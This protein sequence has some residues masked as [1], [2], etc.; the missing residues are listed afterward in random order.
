MNEKTFTEPTLQP[1]ISSASH[2]FNRREL[3]GMKLRQGYP[4]DRCGATYLLD[5]ANDI[6]SFVL[7]QKQRSIKQ[8]AK[9]QWLLTTAKLVAQGS[10][11]EGALVALLADLPDATSLHTQLLV[12]RQEWSELQR[13]LLAKAGQMPSP[14]SGQP[15]SHELLA[16]VQSLDSAYQTAHSELLAEWP[17][18]VESHVLQ[19]ELPKLHDST[20]QLCQRH[21]AAAKNVKQALQDEASNLQAYFQRRLA[22]WQQEALKL[23][24]NQFSRNHSTWS[25]QDH[26]LL[27]QM[28]Q[29]F[30]SDVSATTKACVNE[31]MAALL[32]EKTVPD[33]AGHNEWLWQKRMLDR[34]RRELLCAWD[35]AHKAFLR[36]SSKMLLQ[37][38]KQQ[39]ASAESAAERL[40][41]ISTQHE[42]HDQLK[43]MRCTKYVTDALHAADLE[44]KEQALAHR[45]EEEA[46][47][48]ELRAEQNKQQLALYHAALAA[49]RA[50]AQAA[51]DAQSEEEALQARV[52]FQ[53]NLERVVFRQAATAHK[54]QQ[55][56]EQALLLQQQQHDRED[57]L[58]QLRAQ[59]RVEVEADPDRARAP[60]VA[61]AAQDAEPAAAFA[62]V[63]GYTTETLLKDKRFKVLEAL[64]Q[65]S[66]HNTGY[67]RHALLAVSP[68][69]KPRRDMLST[70]AA[71]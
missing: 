35:N 33:I 47:E 5:K 30:A 34:R 52:L 66:L 65:Q 53:A 64:R 8:S 32:P 3:V 7:R 46:R 58:D 37:S 48:Q 42:L 19:D 54:D 25:Q 21:P 59:V 51:A 43:V 26:D 20:A 23:G 69:T 29:Q 24:S 40:K 38:K 67:A 2:C 39:A 60:T 11:V 18:A 68:A 45:Q 4:P 28:S 36:D 14:C 49:A 31:Y 10:Q 27:A 56:L 71:E 57:R 62:P 12:Y 13:D 50:E 16:V 15:H 6:T 61:S 9:Q 17:T 63:H 41:L 55:R 44:A 22:D 70:A 1:E